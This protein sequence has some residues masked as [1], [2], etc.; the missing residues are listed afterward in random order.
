MPSV[1]RETIEW[2]ATLP[3]WEQAALEKIFS[4]VQF[5]DETYDEILQYLL[6]DANLTESTQ[7]R[8]ILNIFQGTSTDEDS[9]NHSTV[10]LKCISNLRNINALVPNQRLEFCDTLTVIFGSNGSGKSGYA[11]VLASAAFTR[12]D[13]QIL[14]DITKPFNTGNPLCADFE[15]EI[16]G[17]PKQIHYLVGEPFPEMQSFYVFDSTSVRA[18]LLRSH[19]VSFSPAG[20]EYL[21]RLAEVTDAVRRRL[22]QRIDQLNCGNSFP[23]LFSQG[24]TA[25]ARLINQLSAQT[26]ISKI[27]ILGTLSNQ[28]V[29]QIGE[30]DRKIAELKSQDVPKRITEINQTIADLSLLVDKLHAL[31]TALSDKQVE[32]VNQV[33]KEWLEANQFVQET[34]VDQFRNPWFKKTGEKV[35]Q[36]FIYAAYKLSE[37]ESDGKLYPDAESRCLLC[38]QP[39]DASAKDLLL[40]LWNYLLSDAKER[41]S[42]ANNRL[43]TLQKELTDLNFDLLNDQTVS[44]RH[45]QSQD[46]KVMSETSEYI[47]VLKER[48]QTLLT[49]IQSHQFCET[50][51]LP[52]TRTGEIQKIIGRLLGNRNNLERLDP[53]TEIKKLSQEKLELEHRQLLSTI[54]DEVIQFVENMKWIETASSPRVKRSTAHISRKYNELFD[55]LVTQEYLRLFKESL[56]RLHCP[57]IV[58]IETRAQKGETYKQ[59]A[60]QKDESIPLD[61]AQPDKVL[62]EGEQRAVALADFFTEV[63]LDT[64]SCGVVLDDPV[65]SLDFQWKETIA[66][67]ILEEA[68][69]QQVILFTHDLHFLSLINTLAKQAKI[70]IRKHWIQKRGSAPGYVYIDNS[71]VAESEYRKA[72][73]AQ[74]Y[75]EEARKVGGIDAEKEQMYLEHG[76]GALRT[77]YEVFVMHELFQDVVV[78]YQERISGD[79]LKKVYIDEGIRDEVSETIGRLS[80]YIDAHSHSDLGSCLIPTI[81]LLDTEIKQFEDL[82]R[83][84]K[85]IRTDLGIDK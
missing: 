25:V 56:Q 27:R 20:L 74:Y 31:E 30:L 54:L 69:R 67:Y 49:S 36:E 50:G 32:L 13:R 64:Q 80:R 34:S 55:R 1:L 83:R 84:H 8:P 33:I 73:K 19:R 35:W 38:H 47:A 76:F 61:Q 42:N 75:L 39:L 2:G 21:T 53:D 14:P 15:L 52:E 11:R 4:G 29:Q 71:P 24:D 58:R 41:L 82:L 63:Q 77:T 79:R 70:E 26:E 9:Q 6:E 62:S 37:E 68:K 59:I 66:S 57:M 65:T 18:H 45:L 85:A 48:A 16:D 10:R 7:P 46:A 5:T 28:E 43:N 17:S 3:Y 81:E 72:A 60:L 12:G 78:R 40:K 22:Q 23:H 44:S 51:P